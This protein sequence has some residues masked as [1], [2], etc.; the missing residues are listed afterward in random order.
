MLGFSAASWSRAAREGAWAAGGQAAI[1]AAGLLGVRL[2]TEIAPKAVYGEA[3]LILGALLLGRQLFL[4]PVMQAQLR[5]HPKYRIKKQ[6]RW[7]SREIARLAWLGAGAFA[8]AGL[9][10][11]LVWRWRDGGEWRPLVALAAAGI[12]VTDVAKALR[13]N[14]LNAERRQARY[15]VWVGAEAWLW[16]ALSALL[17]LLW[18]STES[19]LAG[20]VAASAVALVL[21]GVLFYPA[22]PREPPVTKAEPRREFVRKVASY[23]LPF[24]PFAV[25][26]WAAMLADRYVLAGFAGRADIGLYTAAYAVAS[27]PFMLVGGMAT[28]LARPVLFQAKSDRPSGKAG[29]VFAL[30]TVAIACVGALGV[31]GFWLFGDWAACLLLAEEYRAGAVGVFMWVAPAYAMAGVAQVIEMRLMSLGRSRALLWPAG[32]G[33]ATNVGVAFLLV[34][35]L[36]VQ[37][38]A[39]AATAGFAVRLLAVIWTLRTCRSR[40]VVQQ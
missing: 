11:Y 37:G 12:L 26:G 1:A 6:T 5:F 33:A 4:G 24:V 34:P 7:F 8:A 20:Q 18:T 21:F 14:R 35:L 13:R 23:A 22:A 29:K 38:A 39:R 30:W 10:A 16:P 28:I 36:G 2:L 32:L 17:L 9:C 25:A 19:Y 27:R 31:L 15:A 40:D 3:A